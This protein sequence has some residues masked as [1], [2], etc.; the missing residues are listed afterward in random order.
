M[1]NIFLAIIGI[2]LIIVSVIGYIFEG[3]QTD[4]KVKELE[5]RVKNLENK[6]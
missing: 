4:I 2:I 3:I 1:T 6:L 5:K